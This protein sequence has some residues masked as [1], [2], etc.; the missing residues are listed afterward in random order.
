MDTVVKTCCRASVGGKEK[1]L[2]SESSG[3][4]CRIGL[5]KKQILGK[6][7]ARE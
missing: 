6:S 7:R 4:S 3:V 5:S 1:G 2:T